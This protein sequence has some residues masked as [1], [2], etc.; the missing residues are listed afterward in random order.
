MCTARDKKSVKIVKNGQKSLYKIVEKSQKY[1]QWDFM[2]EY[3]K[4]SI[5]NEKNPKSDKNVKNDIKKQKMSNEQ[6]MSQ[7]VQ[8]NFSSEI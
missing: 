1:F 3:H 5:G 8:K 7:T 2:S 4:K 6:R